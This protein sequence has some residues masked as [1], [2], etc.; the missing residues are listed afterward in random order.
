MPVS[1][2]VDANVQTTATDTNTNAPTGISSAFSATCRDRR[3]DP[4]MA[5]PTAATV[6]AIPTRT[7]IQGSAAGLTHPIMDSRATHNGPV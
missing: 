1:S 7:A 5:K 3:A 2:P 4:S 6:A